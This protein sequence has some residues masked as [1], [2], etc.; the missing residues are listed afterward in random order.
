M[1]ATCEPFLGLGG[2]GLTVMDAIT[3]LWLL[4]FFLVNIL[5]K[6]VFGIRHLIKERGN[7]KRNEFWNTFL[8]FRND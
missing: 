5:V 3:L 8:A 7:Q 4:L 6:D 2:C 1:Q